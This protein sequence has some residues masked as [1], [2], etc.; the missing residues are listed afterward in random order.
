MKMTQ[1]ML[2]KTYCPI[3]NYCETRALEDLSSH[4]W[5]GGHETLDQFCL[6]NF[7]NCEIYKKKQNN[8]GR[9]IK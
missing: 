1:I 9:E 8:S 3:A 4:C 2:D 6:G 5:V 7:N